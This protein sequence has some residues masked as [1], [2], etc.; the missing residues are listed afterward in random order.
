MEN[1]CKLEIVFGSSRIVGLAGEK[2]VGKT[3]N[4]MALLKDFR[5]QNKETPIYVYGLNETTLNWVK[6]LGN[7]FEVSSLEQLSNKSD[8]L[9]IIDEMQKLKLNDKRYKDVLNAFIDF[10][11]H[12]NNWVI[13]SSP[14]VREFNSVI[15][16]K[17]ERWAL[18]T[19]KCS[20]L[21]NGSHLKDAVYNYNGRYKSIND[22][23]I[24]YNKILI[25]NQD[26]EQEI[27]LEYIKEIDNKI[28]LQNI[29]K[30]RKKSEKSQNGKT[31]N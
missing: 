23:D 18:K 14:N 29:F 12:N 13:L 27:E 26:F 9:I 2:D 10:I 19:I 6:K 31:V 20:N 1:K 17:I 7:L 15:G 8:S 5:Q 30:V 28:N 3:N 25:I 21:V 24:D 11:Y 22:I 16:S 4:L